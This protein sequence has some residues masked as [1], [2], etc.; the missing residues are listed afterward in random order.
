MQ[1]K[2][3]FSLFCFFF[4]KQKTAYEMLRSL[5]G[6]EM[7]IRDRSI[8][9]SVRRSG[10]MMAHDRRGLHMHA[11]VT[12]LI[13]DRSLNEVCKAI[14]CTVMCVG[15]VVYNAPPNPYMRDQ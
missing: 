5:V 11:I 6:S 7:C 1:Y 10:V 14:T 4:F 3:V 12:V 15:I 8:P 2:K 9:P 13:P